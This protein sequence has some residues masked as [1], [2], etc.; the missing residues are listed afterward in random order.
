[1]EDI[2]NKPKT[3]KDYIDLEA[4]REKVISYYESAYDVKFQRELDEY[5]VHMLYS[6]MLQLRDDLELYKLRQGWSRDEV[7]YYTNLWGTKKP[8]HPSV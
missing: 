1:M 2:T 5:T 4:K 7:S 8:K 3:I 6:K